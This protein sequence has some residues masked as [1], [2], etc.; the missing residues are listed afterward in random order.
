MGTHG[1]T[2]VKEALKFLVANVRGILVGGVGSGVGVGVGRV[3]LVGG[4][5]VEI[6]GVGAAAV[7]SALVHPEA[8]TQRQTPATIGMTTDR[9]PNTRPMLAAAA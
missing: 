6:S 3:D 4:V 2:S 8:R 9:F 1:F 5:E 7:T